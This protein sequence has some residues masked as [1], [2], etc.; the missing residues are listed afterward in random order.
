M[1]ALFGRVVFTVAGCPYYWEDVLLA[2]R[3]WGDWKRLRHELRWGIACVKRARTA[4]HFP[5]RRTVQEA[6]ADFR[7]ARGLHTAEAARAWFDQWGLAVDTWMAYIRRS[8]VRQRDALLEKEAMA[9]YPPTR[10]EV[11]RHLLAEAV[12]SGALTRFAGKLASRAA[13]YHR[14]VPPA[15]RKPSAVPKEA[16]ITPSAADCRFLGLPAEAC[17]EKLLTLARMEAAY[18]TFYRQVLTAAALVGPLASRHGDWVLIEGRFAAFADATAAREAALCVRNDGEELEEVAKRAGT[19][20]RT[21]QVFL[22]EIE[23]AVRGVFLS[24]GAGEVL[25]PLLWEGEHRLVRLDA[26][27]LPSFENPDIH[28]RAEDV[29]F[30]RAVDREVNE[31]VRWCPPWEPGP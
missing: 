29:V 20:V 4:R 1:N 26:K 2:A 28:R 30:G 16:D 11:Q 27:V 5:T 19:A 6:A 7:A 31:R 22:E 17:R 8:V 10:R 14:P 24:A 9:A 3:I 23:P 18:K 13:V 25:G 21:V 12:C 15:K